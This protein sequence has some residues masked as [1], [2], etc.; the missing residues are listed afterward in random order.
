MSVTGVP[1][2]VGLRVSE[3]GTY[4]VLGETVTDTSAPSTAL[5]SDNV[6][7]PYVADAFVIV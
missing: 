5:V 3:Y 4:P 2:L 1:S 7:L 6:I